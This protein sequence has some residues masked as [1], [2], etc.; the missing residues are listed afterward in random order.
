[1]LRDISGITSL[2]VVSTASFAVVLFVIV[3]RGYVLLI[4]ETIVF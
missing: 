4:K 3:V 1:M 2:E